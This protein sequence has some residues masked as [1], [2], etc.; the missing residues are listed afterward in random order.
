MREGGFPSELRDSPG[1]QKQSEGQ[2]AVFRGIVKELRQVPG[3]PGA[4]PM[5]ASLNLFR[6]QCSILLVE[7]GPRE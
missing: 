4:D 1:K 5:C 3:L 7:A 2:T 6:G